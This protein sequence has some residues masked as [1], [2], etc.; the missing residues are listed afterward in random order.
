MHLSLNNII[1]LKELRKLV[2]HHCKTVTQKHVEYLA[3]YI[4]LTHRIKPVL[5]TYPLMEWKSF[6]YSSSV[7]SSL[8]K[9]KTATKHPFPK[10]KKTVRL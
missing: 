7:R 10:P 3:D 9:R 8:K 4:D 1:P 5:P 2:V 6:T